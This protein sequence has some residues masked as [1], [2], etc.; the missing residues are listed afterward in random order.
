MSALV[1]RTVRV[2]R[3]PT[4]S[5]AYRSRAAA[6]QRWAKDVILAH[7]ECTGWD[8]DLNGPGP[9]RPCMLC[10]RLFHETAMACTVCSDIGDCGP[11]YSCEGRYAKP[12]QIKSTERY[13]RVKRRLARWLAWRDGRAA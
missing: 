13:Q 6:Y 1:E 3:P 7:C 4:S 5:R 11:C 10:S 2:W 12:V 9:D 8:G